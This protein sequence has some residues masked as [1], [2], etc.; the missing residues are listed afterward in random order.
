MR[1]CAIFLTTA[2]LG[3]AATDSSG[4]WP[5]YGHD[6]GGQRFSPL[7]AI[8]RKN[9][10]TLK[11]A[12]TFRTGDAYRPKNGRPTAFEATPLYIN[13]TLYLSTPLGRVIALDPVTGKQRWS[14]DAKVDRDKGYGDFANRG[15]SAWT[16]PR[17]QLRILVATVD[18]RLIAV[19]AATGKPAK[20]FG[21]N[22]VVNLRHGLRIPP[23]DFSDYE[24]TSPPAVI[25]DTIVVGSGIADNVATDQP[26]G[27][28]RGFDAA[29]GRL[30][31]TWDPIPQEPAAVGADTWKNDS[32]ARTGAAN[33]WSI[34]VTDPVRNLVFVPTGSASPDYYGGERIGDNLF[35]NS[36]VALR[37]DTGKRVW[38][39]RRL[40]LTTSGA[41]M[42]RIVP[43]AA[44]KSASCGQKEFLRRRA[45]GVPSL[46][47][48]T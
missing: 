23:K 42:M 41:S 8:N 33:A 2:F 5:V 15:V 26:S 20:D 44:R 13:G 25:R 10:G 18:A 21:D 14:Y 9:V 3:G 29:S 19:D 31:W 28:V 6:P 12:W 39:R 27:E 45:C 17:G 37:G 35:A 38:H 16:S 40:G 24:E 36:I 43:P 30:K 34:I 11:V 1:L 46:S 32:A 7:T 47:P 22:G 48:A 4:D